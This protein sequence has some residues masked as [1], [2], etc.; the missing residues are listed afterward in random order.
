MGD[1]VPRILHA[2]PV[3]KYNATLFNKL[4]VLQREYIRKITKLPMCMLTGALYGETEMMPIHYDAD[5]RTLNYFLYTKE[6]NLDTWV[7]HVLE[8]QYDCLY[9]KP[10]T[11][12]WLKHFFN[13][14]RNM[15]SI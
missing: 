12:S 9:T 13:M 3:I 4:E 8:E 6:L 14:R 11:K 5:K 2:I 10:N 7:R 1:I 15:M